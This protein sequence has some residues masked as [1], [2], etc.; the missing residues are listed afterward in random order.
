MLGAREWQLPWGAGPV[1]IEQAW[2]HL[3]CWGRER[4]AQLR[5][6]M[7]SAGDCA[8]GPPHGWAHWAYHITEEQFITQMVRGQGARE[9]DLGASLWSQQLKMWSWRNHPP[10]S[11]GEEA[12]E[13]KKSSVQGHLMGWEQKMSQR[14]AYKARTW[15]RKPG[16]SHV[17]EACSRE[18]LMPGCGHSVEATGREGYEDHT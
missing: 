11:C 4:G 8:Q 5:R 16:E 1:S 10:K 12:K 6:P 14:V 15:R 13:A 9:R 3:H 2:R 17:R 18:F 7:E